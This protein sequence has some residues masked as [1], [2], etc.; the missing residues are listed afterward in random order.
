MPPE[1]TSKYSLNLGIDSRLKLNLSELCLSASAKKSLLDFCCSTC[2]GSSDRPLV[3][4]KSMPTPVQ[5]SLIQALNQF[6]MNYTPSIQPGL[7]I[8]GA[9][10]KDGIETLFSYSPTIIPDEAVLYINPAGGAGIGVRFSTDTLKYE[11]GIHLMP[12]GQ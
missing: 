4:F 7:G 1:A 9:I 6:R 10:A 12:S 2:D 8:S 3:D 11:F 5:N